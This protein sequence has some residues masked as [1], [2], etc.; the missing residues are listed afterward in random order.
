VD[1]LVDNSTF[2]NTALPS[3]H[4]KDSVLNVLFPKNPEITSGV[5][6]GVGVI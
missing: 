1:T 6:V 5:F 4:G 3:E 2:V